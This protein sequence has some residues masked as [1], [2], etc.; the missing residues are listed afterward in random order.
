MDTQNDLDRWMISPIAYSI[1]DA[2]QA[3]GVSRTRL[4]EAVRNKELTARKAGRSTIIESDE[5]IR[6]VKSLPT[7]GRAMAEA[8]D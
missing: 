8:R 1:K 3:V 2:P 6:W 5:L 4:F 7:K